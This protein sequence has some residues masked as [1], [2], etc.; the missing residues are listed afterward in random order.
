[1][2]TS[3]PT[4]IILIGMPGAGKSTI[5]II[6]AKQSARDFVDTD[7]LIQVAEKKS[8][9]DILDTE[10]YLAL[11]QVEERVLLSVNCT[12]HVIAT[13]GSAVYSP[14]AM[15]HLKASGIAVFLHVEMEALLKR[16]TNFDTRG[17]A[18]SPEQTFAEL[19]QERQTLYK[20]YGDITIDC[21]NRALE[22]ISTDICDQLRFFRS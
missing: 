14:A 3:R 13:G 2:R 15:N 21:A 9:Q 1:M 5:G 16:I 19:Y 10:G 22:A 18:C 4:N 12:N 20:Q 17:I 8:L 6:L 7:V 11:R